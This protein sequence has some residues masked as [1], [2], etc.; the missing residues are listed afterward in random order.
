MTRP[1]ISLYGVNPC[2]NITSPLQPAFD[3][4][5]RILQVR[6]AAIGETVG[7][8][9]TYKLKRDSIIATIGGGYAD[10]YCRQLGGTASVL[11]GGRTAPVIG[12]ISMD[13]IT[14]DVTK[15]GQ[16]NL[17]TDTAHLI[18]QD[19]PLE[20]MASDLDTIPYEILTTLGH[21]AKRHYIRS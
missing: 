13:S 21:R 11:I 1:G 12:R 9:G 3:W 6:T 20:R 8:G 5:A 7:Y 10:G 18:H 17:H 2:K 15:I 16:D 19:Y 4:K 14:V